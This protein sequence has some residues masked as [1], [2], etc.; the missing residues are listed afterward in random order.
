MTKDTTAGIKSSEEKVL[1]KADNQ[2]QTFS[3]PIDENAVIVLS[4]SNSEINKKEES[5]S[6]GKTSSDLG[7]FVTEIK[8]NDKSYSSGSNE[9]KVYPN[10]DYK[11]EV[12]FEEIDGGRQYGKSPLVFKLPDGLEINSFE[13]KDLIV[14]A[15]NKSIGGNSYYTDGKNI[16]VE[17][18]P[19]VDLYSNVWIRVG[20]SAKVTKEDQKISIPTSGDKGLD[21]TLIPS[22]DAPTI[23]KEQSSFNADTGKVDYLVTITG[24][25]TDVSE[26]TFVDTLGQYLSLKDDYM[27]SVNSSKGAEVT[28]N[29]VGNNSFSG[30]VKNL[31]TG[32]VVTLNYSAFLELPSNL[33][34]LNWNETKNE[35]SYE[36]KLNPNLED[37]VDKD[38]KYTELDKPTLTKKAN[39]DIQ[40]SEDGKENFID[41]EI[42]WNENKSINISNQILTDT[43]LSD[44]KNAE[45]EYV[46][47]SIKVFAVNAKQYLDNPEIS[48]P[49]K[50]SFTF[51][52]PKTDNA[53]S[54]IITY[55]TKALTKDVANHPNKNGVSGQVSN[56]AD[57]KFGNSSTSSAD[58]PLKDG[59]QIYNLEKTGTHSQKDINDSGIST[60]SVKIRVPGDTKSFKIYESLPIAWWNG[61][62]RFDKIVQSKTGE[63]VETI[64]TDELAGL[65]EEELANIFKLEYKL[66]D[67]TYKLLDE[68]SLSVP[69]EGLDSDKFY[70]EVSNLTT[71][72]ET[73]EYIITYETKVNEEFHKDKLE[74]LHDWERVTS[75]DRTNNV[76]L[77]IPSGEDF[78]D[79]ATIK[80]NI[81]KTLSKAGK[82]AEISNDNGEIKVRIPYQIDASII[83]PELD[84]EHSPV[85]NNFVV[86][87]DKV[88]VDHPE[89]W[90]VDESTIKPYVEIETEFG[91]QEKW[92]FNDFEVLKNEDGE[93]QFRFP[94]K[95]QVW[96]NGQ[97]KP[98]DGNINYI[99]LNYKLQPTNLEAILED[100]WENKGITVKNSVKVGSDKDVAENHYYINY[101]PIA[102]NIIKSTSK[103]DNTLKFR[104]DFNEKGLNLN[105][106]EPYVISDKLV[107]NLRLL[108]ITGYSDGVEIISTSSNDFR[109]QVPDGQSGYVEY[110]AQLLGS[111]AGNVNIKNKAYIEGYEDRGTE[112]NAQQVFYSQF[113]EAGASTFEFTLC[114]KDSKGN[115]IKVKESGDED[116]NNVVFVDQAPKFKITVHKA[117]GD[118]S[119]EVELPTGELL[120]NAKLFSKCY[121]N[122]IYF[123]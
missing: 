14:E 30:S 5:R 96:V 12:R 3:L 28:Y 66:P 58:I 50:D 47:D 76:R 37:I 26:I 36:A 103:D 71:E 23:K 73:K 52:A 42:T 107:E 65:D 48:F 44:D 59:D 11:F 62:A 91:I 119:V 40:T 100:N 106:G 35:F 51:K 21:I 6:T 109:V 2:I 120:I 95:I 105:N 90:K 33:E 112:L 16:Y 84:P 87:E 123:I 115:L 17:L 99:R 121:F 80:V 118:R 113:A 15:D 94:Y 89:Y 114:K 77:I 101:K 29:K 70:L 46:E 18:N 43:L 79:S 67:G 85:N 75:Y 55:R 111:N 19:D 97:D 22:D 61:I 110:T 122:Q 53:E 68:A 9:V 4:A 54:Y 56:K 41:W 98:V 38:K 83:S 27:N 63:A 69:E 86:I 39:S 88:I 104:I 25:A 20:F 32:E 74:D 64:N 108:E 45:M 117:D 72:S 10:T 57:D 81:G 24:G 8:I 116:K 1:E 102:K 49:T 82:N 92:D 7:E 13:R 31:H 78:N 60:W 93:F 34:T